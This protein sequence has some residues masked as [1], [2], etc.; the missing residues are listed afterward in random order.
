MIDK[1]EVEQTVL[2]RL[3]TDPSLVGLLDDSVEK[4]ASLCAELLTDAKNGV[5]PNKIEL[6]G[7]LAQLEGVRDQITRKVDKL[8][9]CKK[10]CSYCCNMAVTIHQVDAEVIARHIGVKLN[11]D[12]EIN[13]DRDDEVDRWLGVPCPFL[14]E[15]AC[16]IYSIR[17]SPCRTNSNLSD[18]PDL[19]DVTG[20]IQQVPNLDLRWYWFAESLIIY[21]LG[22]KVGD[23]RTWFPKVTD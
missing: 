17:P 3:G 12:F 9:V 11:Y 18:Y 2:R 4:V 21:R 5:E 23:I 6:M 14:K 1:D 10:G 16:S 8:A 13:T 7:K 22:F 15:G 19:C 20:P